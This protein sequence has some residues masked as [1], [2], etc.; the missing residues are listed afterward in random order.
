MTEILTEVTIKDATQW[1]DDSYARLKDLY[2]NGLKLAANG[3]GW[4][5]DDFW[6]AGNTLH[7]LVNYLVTRGK[8]DMSLPGAPQFVKRAYDIL[9]DKLPYGTGH[10]RDD[11]GW[12]G[13]AFVA[14]YKNAKNLGLDDETT[15]KCRDGALEC[16]ICLHD[17]ACF[18]EKDTNP[19]DKY[20]GAGYAAWNEGNVVDYLKTP[21]T[22]YQ[23]PN[24][25]TDVGFWAL[26]LG[27]YEHVQND[28]KYL[29][30]ARKTFDW[31][32][33]FPDDMLINK[34]ALVQE[35]MNPAAHPGWCKPDRTT[36][37]LQRAW[38]ADQ[39]A[40]IYCLLK[41]LSFEPKDSDRY[42]KMSALAQ[43]LC[44]GYLNVTNTLI[45]KDWVWREFVHN[46]IAGGDHSNFNNNYATGPGVLVRYLPDSF[47][48]MPV[49][50]FYANVRSTM[51]KAITT[52]ANAA[53]NNRAAANQIQLWYQ[54]GLDKTPYEEY[55]GTP[56]DDIWQFAFQTGALDLFVALLKVQ[57]RP[58]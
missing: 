42:K 40:F 25:V 13:N 32:R 36:Q 34:Y 57:P 37:S 11:Y 44:Q 15:E 45:G 47:P 17:S 19:A 20:L 46:P 24:T 18:N 33:S 53:W 6:K 49:D 38:T 58:A 4:M 14:A 10:W 5:W 35:T 3:Q 52:S 30:S 48:L 50:G 7:C 29:E 31:F 8:K 54:K 21:D 56:N 28:E 12:W 22:Y 16:W 41:T 39:G 27:M 43:L 51:A 23:T 2:N 1:A 55:Y 26:S 9:F